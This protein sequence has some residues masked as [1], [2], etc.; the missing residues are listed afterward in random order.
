[1]ATVVVMSEQGR[2]EGRRGYDKEK[3][4]DRTVYRTDGESTGR[5]AETHIDVECPLT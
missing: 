3:N 1:M 2:E 5:E 4:T